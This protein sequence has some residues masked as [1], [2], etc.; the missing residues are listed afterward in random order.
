MFVKICLLNLWHKYEMCFALTTRCNM[1]LWFYFLYVLC[2]YLFILESLNYFSLK[3]NLCANLRETV[4]FN[5][6]DWER[7]WIQGSD[8]ELIISTLSVQNY[9]ITV[10]LGLLKK[11]FALFKKDALRTRW[12]NINT[13][14]KTDF[15]KL[16]IVYLPNYLKILGALQ[17]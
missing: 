1:F 6:H 3:L 7:F 17:Y 2:L 9:C 5:L 8:L 4:G 14:S 11:L 12:M 13:I 10:V 16:F 15:D